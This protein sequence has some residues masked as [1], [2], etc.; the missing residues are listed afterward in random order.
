MAPKR[1]LMGRWG[2]HVGDVL[3]IQYNYLLL[4]RANG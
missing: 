2:L 4:E 1:G 3:H